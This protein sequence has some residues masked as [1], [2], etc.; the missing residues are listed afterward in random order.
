MTD[1]GPE[2]R[3]GWASLRTITR[4]HR[5]RVALLAAVAFTGAM[6]EA[7]FLVLLTAA[8]L[9]LATQSESVGPLL[10]QSISVPVALAVATVAALLRLALSIMVVRLTAGLSARVRTEQRVVVSSAYLHSDWAVQHAEPSGRLQ[11]LLTSFVGQINAAVSAVSGSLTAALSLVAFIAAAFV[12]DPL[13]TIAVLGALLVLG[14]ALSP[15]RKR[16]R[17]EAARGAK[18]DIAFA[19]TVAELSSLGQEMQTFGVR[20]QFERRLRDVIELTTA[21]QKRVQ[22]ASGILSPVYTALSYLAIIAGVAMLQT[23]GV[24]DLVAMGSIMLLMLRSLTYGQQLLSLSGSL[25]AAMPFLERVEATVEHFRSRPA[26]EGDTVPDAVGPLRLMGVGFAYPGSQPVL[27]DVTAEVSAGE[28]VGLIG[29]SGAGKSTLAQL[30]LG[31][32]SPTVGSVSVC[33]VPLPE[34]DRA[35]WNRHVAFV[36]QSPLLIT[37]TVADNI[38]FFRDGLDEDALRLAAERANI[39]GDIEKLPEAFATHLGERGGSLSG[40]QRQRLS[41]ARALAGSPHLIVLDEPTSSLDGQSELLI[42]ETLASLRGSVTLVIIAHRMSTL[43]LCDRIAVVEAGR[44]T[45]FSPPAELRRTN[46]F[47]RRAL[48]ISGVT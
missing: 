9:S 25:A 12:V 1:R 17:K 45:A 34:V 19:T 32:R 13:A 21:Q 20:S 7:G 10:G 27:H 15:I 6:L 16:I 40:G 30:I 3:A 23:L 31:L 24:G 5:R 38:R 41:I 48:Q 11:E 47:Y 8:V 46:T 35:W 42:R 29:P 36:P 39:L 44:V 33:G 14:L 37:G 4:P 22:V 2:T 43:D 26:L 28:M 18:A